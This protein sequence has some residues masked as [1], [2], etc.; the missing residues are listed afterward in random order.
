MAKR[1]DLIIFDWDG[2]LMDSA[3]AIVAAIQAASCDLGLAPPSDESARH[4]IGLGL[5]D[6]LQGVLPDLDPSQYPLVAE[7]YRHHYLARDH[8][9]QLF[10]GAFELIRVLNDAGFMLAV[11]T[12][13][14]RVGLDRA[15]AGSGLKDYFHASRCADECHSKPHP[16][17]IH[18]LIDEFGV[19]PES[20]L[21]IGD[22]THDL[23]MARN[24]SVAALAVAYG[25]H[26]RAV[27]EAEAPLLCASNIAEVHA[28]LM[29][30]A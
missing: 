4:I 22:T 15:L 20:V 29:A 26:P 12:G 30:N 25:A 17:M 1:F 13:K 10:V 7:R 8:E 19:A 9:L 18:E 16:Q 28:W 6:A 21:M 2:T 3:A 5:H 27:L 23:L 14:S 11:A 24:A